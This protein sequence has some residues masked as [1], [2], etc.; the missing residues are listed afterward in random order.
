MEQERRMTL[1]TLRE[2]ALLS[3]ETVNTRA[4]ANEEPREVIFDNHRSKE[5]TPSQLE[6]LDVLRARV[7]DLEMVA[8]EREGWVKNALIVQAQATES[9]DQ[10]RRD[11]ER[12]DATVKEL[13]DE[14]AR[15]LIEKKDAECKAKT[16]V[17]EL[18]NEK[19]QLLF[20]KVELEKQLGSCHPVEDASRPRNDEFLSTKRPFQESIDMENSNESTVEDLLILVASL[21]IQCTVF[22]ES[23]ME[24][25]GEHA[26]AAAAELCKQRGAVFSV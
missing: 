5:L 1:P 26:V 8:K 19:A 4:S 11:K 7:L 25:Q 14:L 21:E 2:T 16:V 17:T 3:N 20:V 13:K 23:L 10:A 18:E 24:A 6:E 15:A 9:D 22:R 12:H